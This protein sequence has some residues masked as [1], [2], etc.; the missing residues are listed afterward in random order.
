MF[1]TFSNVN[2]ISFNIIGFISSNLD[3]KSLTILSLTLFRSDL[4]FF[5]LEKRDEKSISKFSW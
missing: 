5:D 3:E 2:S 4:P 1:I